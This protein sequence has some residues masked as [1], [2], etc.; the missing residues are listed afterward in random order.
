MGL[1]NMCTV[2]SG[3]VSQPVVGLLLDSFWDGKTVEGARVYGLAAYQDAFLILPACFA[4]SIVL[5]L[6]LKETYARP[7]LQPQPS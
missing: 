2:L 6:F 5:W 3:A 7:Y 1:I 4:G